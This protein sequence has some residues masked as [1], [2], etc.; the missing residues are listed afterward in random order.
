MVYLLKRGP[1]KIY[2]LHLI[3]VTL[4][5]FLVYSFFLISYKLDYFQWEKLS[6]IKYLAW[7]TIMLERKVKC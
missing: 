2:P 5:S 1:N 6:F 3:N 4:K 7:D